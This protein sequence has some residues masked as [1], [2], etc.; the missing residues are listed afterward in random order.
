MVIWFGW[1]DYDESGECDVGC[2]CR[3]VSK[4]VVLKKVKGEIVGSAGY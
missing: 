3:Q 1:M 4:S 2:C